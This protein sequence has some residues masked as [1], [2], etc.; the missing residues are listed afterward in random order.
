MFMTMVLVLLAIFLILLAPGFAFSLVLFPASG[1]IGRLEQLII[2]LASSIAISTLV[3]FGLLRT[4]QGLDSQRFITWIS[5]ITAILL[6][7]AFI[8]R[9]IW[10]GRK[11]QINV[12]NS[13]S[14]AKVNPLWFTIPLVA[15]LGIALASAVIPE[16]Q[17][18]LTE[19]YISPDWLIREETISIRQPVTSI[20]VQIHNLEN[21]SAF[22]T[23]QAF[24]DDEFYWEERDILLNHNTTREIMIPV[25]K[26]SA[27]YDHTL[28]I[29]LFTN[30]SKTA[31]A[32]LK[33]SIE[34]ISK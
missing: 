3:G 13:I 33:V 21:Q 29:N 15:A 1:K 5:I 10:Y 32:S 4:T 28:V 9:R 22:Y 31:I 19:F 34:S 18:H 8:E 25:S 2:T 17:E 7:I 6:L 27:T 12:S 24:L 11:T 23:I 30:P 20:P 14:G 26:Y 16:R